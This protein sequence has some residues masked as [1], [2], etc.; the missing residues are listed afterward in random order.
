M[1]DSSRPNFFLLLEIDPNQPWS[2]SVF[3][4]IF[5]LKQTEW[6]KKSKHPKYRMEYNTYLQMLP[7]IKE[8]MENPNTRQI[9]ADYFQQNFQL[10]NPQVEAKPDANQ[11]NQNKPVQKNVKE[12]KKMSKITPIFGIDLGTT[13]SCIAYV[14]EY[15]RPNVVANME[16]D[17]T[18]PSVVQFNGEERIVGKEA[19]NSS[20]LEPDNTV[21]MVKRFM[22]KE[23][24]SFEHEGESY[25]PE[26]ISSYILRKLV[27]DAEQQ[28]SYQI[29]DV[30]ITCPAY[31]GIREREA[32]QLAGET[33]GLNVRSIINEPTAAA[34]CYGVNEEADQTVLVY[35]LGG[36]TFDI[37]V[38]KI[39]G[40]NITVVCTEGDHDLGGKNWDETIVTYLAQQWQ[41]ETGASEDPLESPETLQELYV[42][43]EDAK[44]TLTQRGETSIPVMHN[45]QRKK[46]E[47]TRETFDELTESLLERTIE[48]TKIAI[49]EAKKRGVEDFDQILMVGGSTKMPQVAR[50][51]Q[52]ELGKE[53]KFCE[54]DESVAKGAA[55]FGH[56]LMLDQEIRINISDQLGLKPEDV[57]LEDVPE[58]TKQKAE[59]EVAKNNGLTLG[60]VQKATETKI[61]NVTSCSFGIK[62]R[63]KNE[64]KL[65]NLIKKNDPVPADVTQRFGTGS[66]NQ[67]SVEL[68]IAQNSSTDQYYELHLST[69]IGQAEI[70]LPSGLPQG[71]P[72]DVT[73]KLNEQ[74]MLEM[75][76]KELSTGRDATVTIKTEGGVTEEEKEAMKARNYSL[77]YS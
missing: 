16:G 39:E 21:D 37:T 47:L 59:Q 56:K 8:V 49:A 7:E 75:Y 38:I 67:T 64:E 25:R 14:D 20:M 3:Q 57:K 26:E 28:T 45:M 32:T 29:K 74:G 24:F 55:I 62:A 11:M 9:E 17:R 66:A 18:T 53:P 12:T 58:E 73:F 71:T 77:V 70:S 76:A 60:A 46:I 30:V 51:I 43:A 5:T 40:G 41:E 13:Y 10:N 34:I 1:I 2:D 48:L 61:I 31:F 33:A 69:E 19:K 52:E 42:R 27:K 23:G 54:P 68:L 6:T 4:E 65:V 63:V 35:D 72:I 36:G 22:G 50:R 15:G 44:K